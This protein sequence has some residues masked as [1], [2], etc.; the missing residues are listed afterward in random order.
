VRG[1]STV[2]AA[3][4]NAKLGLPVLS[5]LARAVAP[6]R[7]QTRGISHLML[8]N[9]HAKQLIIPH[10]SCTRPYIPYIRM[11]LII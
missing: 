10:H 3:R 7:G 4:L 9:E 2:A 8:R 6:T 5:V 1:A 11:H